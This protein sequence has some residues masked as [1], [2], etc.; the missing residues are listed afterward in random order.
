M[1]G[2]PHPVRSRSQRQTS[3]HPSKSP[4]AHNPEKWPGHRPFKSSQSYHT[5]K[6]TQ[7]YGRIHPP[8]IIRKQPLPP[9][10][11][12]CACFL[13]IQTFNPRMA[14]VTPVPKLLNLHLVA[15]ASTRLLRRWKCICMFVSLR[16][17]EGCPAHMFTHEFGGGRNL[18]LGAATDGSQAQVRPRTG[19]V[20]TACRG[21]T[22]PT[23]GQTVSHSCWP[24]QADCMTIWTGCC[25]G[26]RIKESNFS[27]SHTFRA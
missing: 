16:L 26:S 11:T 13:E 23:A 27:P 18:R 6:D 2:A 8:P 14:R 4:A 17:K 25:A 1:R 3:T 19:H 21:M 20:H 12:F 5:Q 10:K 15:A 7:G 24:T 9:M 22:N